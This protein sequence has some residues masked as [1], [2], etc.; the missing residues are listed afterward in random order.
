MWDAYQPIIPYISFAIVLIHTG[1]VIIS[2]KE[3]YLWVVVYAAALTHLRAI[4]GLVKD[5]GHS[6]EEADEN[7]FLREIS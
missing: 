5:Q 2:Y 1:L 4:F 3:K 7:H 6:H